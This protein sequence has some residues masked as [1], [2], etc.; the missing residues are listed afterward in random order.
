MHIE[1]FKIAKCINYSLKVSI[2]SSSFTH[3]RFNGTAK[4]LALS[5]KWLNEINKIEV[6]TTANTK[7]NSMSFA[8]YILN[9]LI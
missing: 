1:R 6:N 5:L 9:T 4:T 7:E 3:V 2:F 8:L